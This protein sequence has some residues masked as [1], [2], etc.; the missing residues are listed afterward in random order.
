MGFDSIGQEGE[1]VA[2]L[3]AA[4]FD[5]RQHRLDETAAAG[6]LRPERKLSPNHC[7]TKRPL[8]R[9]V[10]RFDSFVAQERP[11][12]LPVSVQLPARAAHVWIAAFGAAQQQALH[13]ATDGSHPTHKR[14]ARNLAG[15]IV[16][17]VLEQLAGQTPQPETQPLALDRAAVDHRLKIAFQMGP[18]PLQAPQVPVHFGPI[19]VDDAA[20]RLAQQRAERRRLARGTHR[21][22]REH[23]GYEGPQPRLAVF[24]LGPRFVDAQLLLPRQFV[25]QFLIR[26][27][28]GRRHPVLD[29]HRQRR[30]TGLTQERAQEFR[31]PPLA[32]TIVGHQQGYEGHQPW[33]R[34]PLGHAC[35]QL[36]TGRFTAGGTC[37]PMPL[38]LG[39]DGLDL[40]Q[41][42][43]LV[44][45]RLRVAARELLA[46]TPTFSRLEWLHA[47]A[48]FGGNQR[49]LVLFVAG[50]PATLLLRLAFGRLRP[51]VR[52]LRARRQ[53][54]VLRRLTLP[55]PFQLLDPRPQLDN[56]RQQRPNNRLGFRRLAGNDF[57]R[58]YQ[59]HAIVVTEHR[60]PCPDQFTEKMSPGRER[61][62]WDTS[63]RSWRRTDR[64]LGGRAPASATSRSLAASAWPRAANASAACRARWPFF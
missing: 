13:L 1:D 50:L 6:A 22:H 16:G 8:A 40:G 37:Q 47:V 31:C 63:P 42:P 5:H 60:P 20:K 27:P 54:R 25:R 56:L 9:I 2:A 34:L 33:P 29:F 23:S 32:L 11:Q 39:H 62:P 10:R 55:L 45:Q 61:L 38:V 15:A 30:T 48:V 4:G 51:G 44:P 43:H 46:T 3:L 58:D 41:F 24:L 36:R 26:R 49:P 12:P 52:M 19:A 57:F 53:R 17:P 64:R 28:H 18:A 35:G 7:M 59:R 14:R 21:K